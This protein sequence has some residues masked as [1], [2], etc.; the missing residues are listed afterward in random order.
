MLSAPVIL[1]RISYDREQQTVQIGLQSSRGGE[2][3]VLDVLDFVARLT[4]QIPDPHERL[5]LY[6]SPYSNASRQ[7]RVPGDRDVPPALGDDSTAGDESEWQR[8][9]RIRWVKLIKKSGK[10]IPCSAPSAEVGCR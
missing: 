2:P 7:R 10:K 4:V 6:Y 5:V 1:S 3:A 8:S 9:R